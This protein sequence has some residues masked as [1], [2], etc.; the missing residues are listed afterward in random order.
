[1]TLTSPS[2]GNPGEGWGGGSSNDS[3]P[4]DSPAPRPPPAPRSLIAPADRIQVG[5]S[6]NPTPAAAYR[7]SAATAGRRLGEHFPPTRMSLDLC[8]LAS[9]SGGNCTVLRTP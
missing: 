4:C 6:G 8:I 1:E 2:P 3:Q 9:G 5:K 7:L